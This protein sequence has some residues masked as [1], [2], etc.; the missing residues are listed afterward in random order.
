MPARRGPTCHFQSHSVV[1]RIDRGMDL[2]EYNRCHLSYLVRGVV[3]A[4][5]MLRVQAP[6]A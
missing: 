6:T 3:A 5:E 2:V 4:S 1:V